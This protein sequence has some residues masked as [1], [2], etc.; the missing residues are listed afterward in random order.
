MAGT[1]EPLLKKALQGKDLNR[2][3]ISEL[4]AFDRKEELEKL[5]QTADRIRKKFVGEE[6]HLRGIV[7]FSN[8]CRNNCLY[9]GIRMGNRKVRRYRMS[10]E[11]IVNWVSFIAQK[12]KYKTVVLQSGEDLWYPKGR[13]VKIIKEIKKRS[14]I[15]VVVSIGERDYQTYKAM[16]EA[17]A[18]RSLFRFETTNPVLYKKMT[19]RSLAQ[20][21]QHIKWMKELGYQVG[22]GSL[23]G[24]PGAGHGD[25]VEDILFLKKYNIDM[26][27]M[28][29]YICHPDTPLAGSPNGDVEF[30]LKM[31]AVVRL[32]CQDVHMPSTTALQTLAHL[33]GRPRAL[34]CGANILMPN[35]TPTKYRK[36]YLLYPNKVCI[37]EDPATSRDFAVQAIHSLGRKIG[38]GYG[39]SLKIKNL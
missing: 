19:G 11:E 21:I 26:A 23:I 17:G 27:A 13:L 8:Y 36:Y 32:V 25:Y 28:G 31:V 18:E 34:N 20:R 30:S 29:P 39:H 16:R 9:C 5:F 12:L 2:E 14:K 24:L 15:A 1:I 3:E 22:T 6:V 37:F 10:P 33:D 38:R 7:E 4:L 35:A